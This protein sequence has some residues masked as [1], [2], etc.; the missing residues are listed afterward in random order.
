[1]GMDQQGA[2]ALKQGLNLTRDFMDMV[3]DGSGGSDGSDLA[4]AQAGLTEQDAL[5]EAAARR[6]QAQEAAADYRDKA[7]HRRAANHASWGASGLAMSGSKRII[8]QSERLKDGQ[9]EDDILFRGD[10]EAQGALNQGRNRANLTRIGNG[11][12]ANRSTLSLGS[13]LYK[14]GG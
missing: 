4:E 6:R 12:S 10:R 13:K 14:Y 5:G 11:A 2:A 3:N 9:E 1:M 8:N 7:E